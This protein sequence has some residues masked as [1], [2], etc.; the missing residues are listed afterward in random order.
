MST[1]MIKYVSALSLASPLERAGWPYSNVG[2][3][4]RCVNFAA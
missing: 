4:E 2:A 3:V 1:A